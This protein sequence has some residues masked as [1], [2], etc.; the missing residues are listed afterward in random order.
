MYAPTA[1]CSEEIDIFYDNLDMTKAQC[2]SQ[3]IIIAMGDLKAKVGSEGGS[4]MVGEHGLV[5]QN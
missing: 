2:K 5:I 3:E 4:D 1:D